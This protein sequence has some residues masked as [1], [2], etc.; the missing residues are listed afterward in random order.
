M[1]LN[2]DRLVFYPAD[3]PSSDQVGSYLIGAGGLVVTS[4]TVGGDEALDVNIVQSAG[5]YAEDSVHASGDLG[6]M[7]LV[8]RKDV[9]GTLAGTDGD[10]APLQVNATGEL[11]VSTSLSSAIADDAV[12]TENPIKMGSHA[13]SG[14]LAAISAAGDKANLASDLYR[15]IFVNASPTVAA[16]AAAQTVTTSAAAIPATA[17]AGR[18][19]V[20]LQNLGTKD[21][22]VGHSAGVTVANGLRIASGATLEIPCGEA[23]GL[24][25]IA[26]SGSQ[27]VRVLELG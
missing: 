17:L 18:T 13:Y 4:T 8:V 12:D 2:K 9:A 27:S 22:Y 5:Q 7:A 14:A 24:F 3:L 19:R 6:T 16:L 21:C 23:V 20:I 1:G 10:Y 11:R 26:A 15:R 25:A